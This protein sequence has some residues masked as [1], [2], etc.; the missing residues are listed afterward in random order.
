MTRVRTGLNKGMRWV[1]GSGT[2]GCWLGLYELEKQIAIKPFV[3]PGMTVFDIGANAGFYTLAFSRLVG[4]EGSVWAFEPFA[5]NAN[6]LLRHMKVN[7]LDNVTLVQ[8][9]LADQGGI[10][11]FKVGK[12][13]YTGTIAE[14][15]SY[16]VPALVLDEL[17]ETGVAPVPDVI[18]IDVEGAESL[19]LEGARRLLKSKKTTL[20]ISLHGDEEKARCQKI[21]DDLEYKIFMLDGSASNGR[22]LNDDV[23]TM[24]KEMFSR[25][26]A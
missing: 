25:R 24:P 7:Q 3:Q 17:V 16:K 18:K 20:F 1:V 5:E 11:G 8:A 10:M 12:N 26:R 22:P 21:L 15:E 23:F 9:A 4:S 13:H 2:H 6:N 14:E 19:V